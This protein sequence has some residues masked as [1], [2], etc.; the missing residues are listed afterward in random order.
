MSELQQT[1]MPKRKR[2]GVAY[3]VAV[4]QHFF[5]SMTA[6]ITFQMYSQLETIRGDYRAMSVAG[7]LM[8]AD[9]N[10]A[11]IAPDDIPSTWVLTM[12]LQPI[13]AHTQNCA[14]F[15]PLSEVSRMMD[16]LDV[17]CGT[18]GHRQIINMINALQIVADDFQ[19]WAVDLEE[20]MPR[21]H[22]EQAA[23]ERRW[24]NWCFMVLAAEEAITERLWR[25]ETLLKR[26]ASEMQLAGYSELRDGVTYQLGTLAHLGEVIWEMQPVPTTG[27]TI[28]FMC[29]EI[30]GYGGEQA[31]PL[32]P[33]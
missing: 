19:S 10:G 27:K 31:V 29:P 23:M 20:S 3:D 33:P 32:L 4:G 16:G 15:P 2:A 26:H 22:P 18:Y 24:H 14:D 21:V 8:E 7:F 9:Q 28:A 11:R 25:N 5:P 12:V 6:P 17:I 30:F 13:F 1:N